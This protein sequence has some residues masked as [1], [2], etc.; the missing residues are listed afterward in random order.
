MSTE[1]ITLAAMKNANQPDTR[2]CHTH[3][4]CD[5]NMAMH[6]AFMRYNIDPA[7][8]G[9]WKNCAE[10]W[11]SAWELAKSSNFQLY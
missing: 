1:E 10:L 2:I 5:A 11:H 7:E 8:E 3:D 4:Y 6:A 9:E